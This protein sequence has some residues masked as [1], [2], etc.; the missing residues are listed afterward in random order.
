MPT[1]KS[2]SAVMA[3]RVVIDTGPLIAL[4]R[5]GALEIVGA[6]PFEFLCPPEVRRELDADA[7]AGR[8]DVNPSWLIEL[9]L[10]GPIH[11]IAAAVLD[12]GEASV[13]QLALE[14]GV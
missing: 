9:A 1:R 14:H 5:A 7:T 13:I 2:G 4:A 3:D 11:P 10:R 8:V 6:L 12:P